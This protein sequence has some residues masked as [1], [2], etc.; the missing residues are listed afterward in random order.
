M[1]ETNPASGEIVFSTRAYTYEITQLMSIVQGLD[2]EVRDAI[3]G[4]IERMSS[5]L[6]PIVTQHLEDHPEVDQR[7]EFTSDLL[8]GRFNGPDVD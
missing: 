6:S 1:A 2:P 7:S 4:H 8:Y 5:M 3:S